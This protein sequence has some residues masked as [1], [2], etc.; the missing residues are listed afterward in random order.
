MKING[1]PIDHINSGVE[2]PFGWIKRGKLD[3][4]L[5]FL[6]PST[7]SDEDIISIVKEEIDDITDL[8][9][10]KFDEVIHHH[11]SK[12]NSSP[13]HDDDLGKHSRKLETL[14]RRKREEASRSNKEIQ[15]MR[16][17][18]DLASNPEFHNTTCY[19][20]IYPVYSD[21]HTPPTRSVREKDRGRK[22]V[23]MFWNVKMNDLKASVPY[24]SPDLSYIS[25]AMIRPIVAYM[26]ANRTC[27]PFSFSAEMELVWH[28][29]FSHM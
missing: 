15:G 3:I 11:E 2:G 1:V 18:V 17:I 26:N 13:D 9:L 6:L 16:K 10:D 23:V 12:N 20:T 28:K 27:T 29:L 7:D 5:H 19:K 25:N 24:F 8:A 14:E 22:K 21:E 4:D